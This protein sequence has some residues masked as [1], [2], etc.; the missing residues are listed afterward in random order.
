M[1]AQHLADRRNTTTNR[2]GSAGQSSSLIDQAESYLPH[3]QQ[4]DSGGGAVAP[5]FE[6]ISGFQSADSNGNIPGLSG[7][8]TS[9]TGPYARRMLNIKAM[10]WQFAAWQMVELLIHPSKV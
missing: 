1:H 6:N 5:S 3:R 7:T 2:K 8:S 10:D 4:M 9:F